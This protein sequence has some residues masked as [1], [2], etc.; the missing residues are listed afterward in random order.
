MICLDILSI[1]RR[2]FETCVKALTKE[3]P[4]LER[5]ILEH[6][7]KP[8]VINQ[9]AREIYNIEQKYGRDR[10][11]KERNR[12]IAGVTEMFVKAAK[13]FK[14]QQNMSDLQRNHVSA[15]EKAWNDMEVPVP[16]RG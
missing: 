4:E 9:M 10:V 12:I 14:E 13:A 7:R 15:N 3:E 6:E 1:V 8:L 16:L 11:N 5:F 2:D